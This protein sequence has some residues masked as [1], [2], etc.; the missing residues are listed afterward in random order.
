[1]ARFFL[2]N[3]WIIL[4]KVEKCSLTFLRV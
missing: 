3:C 1:L 2:T 4:I